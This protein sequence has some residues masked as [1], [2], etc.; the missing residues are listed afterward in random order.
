[1][2]SLTSLTRRTLCTGRVNP[3][4]PALGDPLPSSTGGRKDLLICGTEDPCAGDGAELDT[5]LRMDVSSSGRLR[6]RRY[7]D[8]SAL[9]FPSL[10]AV[11]GSSFPSSQF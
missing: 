4:L 6:R 9:G 5:V 7:L 8:A 10:S 3:C 1:M 2:L 11:E